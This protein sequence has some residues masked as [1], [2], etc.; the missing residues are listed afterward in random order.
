LNNLFGQGK[1]IDVQTDKTD[2][3]RRSLSINYSQPWFLIGLGE[4]TIDVMSRD[5]RDEFYE[6][7]LGTGYHTRINQSFTTGL[8]I[9]WKSVKPVMG[10]KSYNNYSG[11]FSIKK[12][13]LTDQFN[14]Q[15]GLALSGGVELSHRQYKFDGLS[16]SNFQQSIN[17]TKMNV[18][19]SLFK[20]MFGP[21]IGRISLNY[22]G[23]ESSEAIP[24]L[25]ELFLIGGPGSLRGFRNEQFPAIRSAYGTIEPRIRFSQG[26]LFAF[27]DAAYLNNRHEDLGGS[28]KTEEEYL[29]S[30]GLGFGLGN[31][32]RNLCLSLGVNPDQGLQEPR[33]SI[34]LSSD[35]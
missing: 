35:I 22:V 31:R 9:K 7:S 5:F 1:Q 34:E 19:L 2:E 18:Q 14:P 27:C 33:L 12:S 13:T 11:G 4:M 8:T 24:P 6:F 3:K 16:E 26:Y 20:P 23:L 15:K 17:E 30:Y 29:W 21:V 25:S 32:G 10:T 28:A